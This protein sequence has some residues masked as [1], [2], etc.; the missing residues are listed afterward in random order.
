MDGLTAPSNKIFA[1]DFG[2]VL[3]NT[4]QTK[5]HNIRLK[6]H[7]RENNIGVLNSFQL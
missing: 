2:L 3:L 7:G 5:Q 6:F 1:T 4:L